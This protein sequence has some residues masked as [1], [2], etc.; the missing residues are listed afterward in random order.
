MIVRD[1]RQ[2]SLRYQ[3]FDCFSPLLY[4]AC[5]Q[6]GSFV[7]FHMLGNALTHDRNGLCVWRSC[8]NKMDAVRI[9]LHCDVVADHGGL[10]GR[11]REWVCPTLFSEK[12]FRSPI[13]E[14]FSVLA[15]TLNPGDLLRVR[16]WH[17]VGGIIPPIFIMQI[18]LKLLQFRYPAPTIVIIENPR[19][20]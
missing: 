2:V 10:R 4:L 7:A 12:T 8:E 14:I 9:N 5:E 1:V 3:C 6:S 19:L 16:S 18:C 20:V 13:V 17:R 15:S 11:F